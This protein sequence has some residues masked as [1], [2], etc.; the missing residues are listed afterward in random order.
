MHV[1]YYINDL[2]LPGFVSLLFGETFLPNNN[3]IGS[4]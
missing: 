2:F 3:M 1:L 4:S